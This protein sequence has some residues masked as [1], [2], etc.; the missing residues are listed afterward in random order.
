MQRWHGTDHHL[1]FIERENMS[2]KALINIFKP[3][4]IAV[5]GASENIYSYGTRFIQAQLDFGYKGKIYAINP[6]GE[7]CLGLKIYRGLDD[8]DD[9]IDLAFITVSARWII[10]ILNQCIA[11]KI[12]AAVAFAAGFSETGSEGLKL[13][14][15]VLK[16]IDGKMLLIGPNCFGPYCPG[17]GITTVTGGEFAKE[18]GSVALIAQSGQLTENIIARAQ[19]EGVRHSKFASYGNIGLF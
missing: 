11:R 2:N 7:K 5:F 10:D 9:T 8:I 1:H 3:K 15:E 4:T 13:E 6:K 17:G 18:S 14:K 19:G 12:K 16:T